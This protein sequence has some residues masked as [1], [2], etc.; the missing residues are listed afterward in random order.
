MKKYV[1]GLTVL[2]GSTAMFTSCN[3]DSDSPS[4]YV[5]TF[6]NGAYIVNQ[7]SYSSSYG[8]GSLTFI[9]Y[10]SNTASQ[11]VFSKANNGE[12]IGNMAN[13][14]CVYGSKIYIVADKS[15]TIEVL[16]KKTFKRLKQIKTTDLMGTEA[17]VE[18]RHIIAGNGCV[19]FTTYGGNS[20][21]GYV[22]A[23]DTASYTLKQT[24]EV[25]SYPEGL[26]GVS[27]GNTAYIY[28]A[29]SDYGNGNGNI[30]VIDLSGN[31]VNTYTLSGIKNPQKVFVVSGNVYV[32]DYGYYDDESWNQ[33]G[34][35]LKLITST[36]ATN[37]VDCTLATLYDGKLYYINSPY[38][39]SEVSYGVY[40]FTNSTS[41]AWGLTEEVESPAGIEADPVTG[42]IFI[43]SYKMGEYDYA[44]YETAGYVN[45]YSTTGQK[46]R[47]YAT[48]VGPVSMFFDAGYN[49]IER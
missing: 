46:K 28:V 23:V 16:D 32:L 11:Q 49:L 25:G 19:Y 2:L 18:P 1:L 26:T 34:A 36:S 10:A 47:Q 42:S 30:S 21:H 3:D 39:A 40:D 14:G 31:T 48:G 35:G 9:D 20:T 5:E 33:K 22:A 45:E 37:V 17:G 24:Y 4:Y 7:G 6:S 8:N 43:M 41:N 13:D 44:D 29:N 27:N 38:G 12:S 15:N